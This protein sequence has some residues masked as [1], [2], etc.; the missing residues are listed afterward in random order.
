MF[1]KEENPQMYQQNVS[2]YQHVKPKRHVLGLVGGNDVY[3]IKGNRV[4]LESD[5]LGITRPNT[6]GNFREHLPSKNADTIDRKN[7]K[8]T[9]SINATPIQREEYQMWSYPAVFAPPTFKNETCKQK[10]KF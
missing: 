3:E 9:I 10:Q 8:N 4:D 5:L 1:E 6:W 7:P 2:I